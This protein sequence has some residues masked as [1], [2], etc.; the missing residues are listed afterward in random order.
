M[1]RRISYDAAAASHERRLLREHLVK[2]LTPLYLGRTASYVL[3][4]EGLTSAEAES[5]I[6]L[7]CDAFEKHKPDLRERWKAASRASVT[8]SAA[9]ARS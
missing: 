3:E 2:A 1:Y 6:E 5:P 7:L 4:T 9:D 8:L